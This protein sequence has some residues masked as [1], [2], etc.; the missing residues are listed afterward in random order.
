MEQNSIQ[1]ILANLAAGLT[2]KFEVM[3]KLNLIKSYSIVS[4]I[5]DDSYSLEVELNKWE[6]RE[7]FPKMSLKI[8]SRHE[9][10]N[11]SET[12]V[13]EFLNQIDSH[14]EKSMQDAQAALDAAQ[15]RR[16]MFNIF[17]K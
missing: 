9:E 10:K 7:E 1:E 12:L 14:V 16:D 8:D 4:Y 15:A 11:Y 13:T 6:W 5:Y 3:K 17:K 2:G